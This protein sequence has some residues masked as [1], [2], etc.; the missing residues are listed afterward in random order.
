M[1]SEPRPLK[2]IHKI[3]EILSDERKKMTDKEKLSAIHREAEEAKKKYG[4][5][6]RRA[7]YS[8]EVLKT[9]LENSPL[10]ACRL[11]HCTRR[12][13]VAAM[14]LTTYKLDIFD[15][16]SADAASP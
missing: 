14:S 5:V 9:A 15:S 1:F 12:L 7:S 6:L 16:T 11:S 3:Q 10:G 4:F 8:S 13:L 2:E